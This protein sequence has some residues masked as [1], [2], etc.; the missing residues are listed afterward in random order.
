M[1]AMKL[2]NTVEVLKSLYSTNEKLIDNL[3]Q[4]ITTMEK[5][6]NSVNLRDYYL[7]QGQCEGVK[8]MQNM[9]HVAIRLF[10]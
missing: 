9:L 5:D 7:L 1:D 8:G 2:P 3:T 4:Q 10:E 6:P